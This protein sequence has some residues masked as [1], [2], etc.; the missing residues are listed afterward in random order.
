MNYALSDFFRPDDEK[1]FRFG[2][3]V[4]GNFL[5]ISIRG[6]TLAAHFTYLS[7]DD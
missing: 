7:G 3:K 5:S 2:M 4:V 1:R 6:M